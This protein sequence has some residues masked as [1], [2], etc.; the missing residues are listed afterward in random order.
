MAD[1]LL[2]PRGEMEGVFRSILLQHG[3]APEKAQECAAIFTANS[4][5]GVYSHGVNRFALFVQMVRDGH[6]RPNA[7]P[8]AVH[9]T[10]ALEQWDG[11][12]APGVL[13][14]VKATE[15]AVEL[16]KQQGLG[17]VALANTNHWMRG[18]Y[19][20]WLAARAGCVF[21]GWSNTIANMPAYGATDVRL[22][23]NPLVI[24]LPFLQEAMVLDMALSQFSYGAMQMAA[25]K[26]EGLP[27]AGGYDKEG[28]LTNDPS[29]ILA[30][31]RTVPIGYWKGAGLS[32]LLDVVAAVLSGGLATHKI[33][34]QKIEKGLSQV[35]FAIDLAQLKNYRSIEACIQAVVD[36]YKQSVADS[37]VLYPGERV[38]QSRQR[39]LQKGI[40]VAA[41]IWEEI[42]ALQD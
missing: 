41:K 8:F 19:Y 32:L 12:L 7:E 15:R 37:E 16:A 5:D 38:L 20:G 9:T 29:A 31:S 27:V 10:P 35:F 17:C 34:S 26:G 36:D 4:L 23:N 6:V 2:I 18:G 1:T 39:N 33:S 14:A 25:L 13:N 40:P 24:A 11:A 22:G 3:F 28:N 21:I 42:L 30:T